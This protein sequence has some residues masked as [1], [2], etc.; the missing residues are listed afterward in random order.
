MASLLNEQFQFQTER[1]ATAANLAAR[2]QAWQ[3]QQAEWDAQRSRLEDTLA[4]AAAEH[5]RL[6]AEQAAV[7]DQLRADLAAQAVAP[8]GRRGNN[9]GRGTSCRARG[10]VGAAGGG[11]QHQRAEFEAQQA[12][13]AAELD[14]RADSLRQDGLWLAEQREALVAEQGS[15][16]SARA[17]WETERRQ[18]FAH[19]ET[20]ATRLRSA[21][22]SWRRRK[23][24][25]RKSGALSNRN[26]IEQPRPCDKRPTRRS[27]LPK[28][29]RTVPPGKPRRTRP[30]TTSSLGCA[31]WRCSRKAHSMRRVKTAMC[32]PETIETSALKKRWQTRIRQTKSILSRTTPTRR[33]I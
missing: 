30:K 23:P 26:S 8:H 16:E 1:S 15:W 33:T 21:P 17:G 12:A 22:T 20:E 7:N 31:A 14:R 29:A 32:R 11:L 2:E 10:R 6:L 19:L 24:G 28:W 3:Q 25:L 4:R 18:E 27:R 9:C 13:Q 5:A